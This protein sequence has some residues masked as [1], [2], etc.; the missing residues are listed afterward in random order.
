MDA[1]GGSET[2]RVF[3]L[4]ERTARFGEDAV[5][6]ARR[7]PPDPVSIPLIRQLVRAATSIGANYCEADEAGSRKEFRYRISVSC[8]ESRESKHWLRML[9]VAAPDHKEDARILWKEAHELNLI[10]AAIARQK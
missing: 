5:R 4:A 9:A 7:I 3:D 6:F 10:F 8:R 1:A 2:R